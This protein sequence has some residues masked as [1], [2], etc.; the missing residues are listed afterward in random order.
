[1]E[2]NVIVL[3]PAS[4]L[5]GLGRAALR[6]NW[7]NAILAMFLAMLLYDVAGTIIDALLGTTYTL[8]PGVELPS[9]YGWLYQLAMVGAINV[10]MVAFVIRMFRHQDVRIAN[11]FTGF[12]H[13]GKSFVLGLLLTIFVTLW[14]LLLVVPGI[15]AYFRYSQ[16]YFIMQDRPELSAMDC[17]R[18]SKRMMIGNKA[19]LFTTTLSFIGWALLSQTP[20]ILYG[21][22][23]GLSQATE[24]ILSGASTIP[25]IDFGAFD[26]I[27]ISIL[28]LG[29]AVVQAYY[30]ITCA[31][32]YE[33]LNGH[34]N[35]KVFARNVTN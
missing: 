2:T 14:A 28:S 8:A 5:R 12:E 34:L 22:W 24:A 23:Y 7:Q 26:T 32:F 31:A 6:G 11:I 35:G 17:I 4:N 29:G 30:N 1:M 33:L 3:E 10:G 21:V 15:I 13:F 19:K 25:S 9:S 18:E 20:A 16:A 27:I